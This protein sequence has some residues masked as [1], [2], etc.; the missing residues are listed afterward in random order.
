MEQLFTVQQVLHLV[1]Y[2]RK[3]KTKLPQVVNITDKAKDDNLHQTDELAKAKMS[4]N[5]DRSRQTKNLPI[6]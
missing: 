1:S 2:F 6:K 3:I 4:L 5:A